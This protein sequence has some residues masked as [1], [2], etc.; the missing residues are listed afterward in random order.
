MMGSGRGP[1]GSG[2]LGLR[3]LVMTRKRRVT[4][5]RVNMRMDC[6]SIMALVLFL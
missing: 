5:G 4:N 2:S 3:R 6:M 1:G